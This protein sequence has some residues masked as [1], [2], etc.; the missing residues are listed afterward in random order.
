ME[1]ILV[2][3]DGSENALRA[4]EHAIA[5]AKGYAQAELHLLYVQDPIPPHLHLNSSIGNSERAEA[6][7]TGQALQTA[8]QRCD[9]ASVS[10]VAHIRVGAI[11]QAIVAG[12][13]ELQ[14]NA[15]VMGTR[16]MNAI[17]SLIIGS[18]TTK[19][20]PLAHVPMTLIE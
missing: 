5:V 1:K 9:E 19:V 4:V 8:K 13:D 2:P 6:K 7:A 11:A 3:V 16:G 20:I 15:I 18:V 10:C 12:A 17:A 14:C